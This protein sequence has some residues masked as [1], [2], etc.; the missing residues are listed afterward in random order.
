MRVVLL[1]QEGM[2]RRAVFGNE[3]MPDDRQQMPAP[4]R[5]RALDGRQLCSHRS[6]DINTHPRAEDTLSASV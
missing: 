6:V 4:A 5:D 2:C 1:S 3:G